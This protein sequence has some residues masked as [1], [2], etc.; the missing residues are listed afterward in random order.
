MFRDDA[1]AA[2]SFACYAAPAGEIDF[3]IKALLFNCERRFKTETRG[4]PIV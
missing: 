4:G 3:A 2:Y 1:E